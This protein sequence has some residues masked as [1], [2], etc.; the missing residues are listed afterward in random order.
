M[1]NINWTRL[2]DTW[3]PTQNRRALPLE[4]DDDWVHYIRNLDNFSASFYYMYF[5]NIVRD[6][7]TFIFNTKR[8]ISSFFFSWSVAKKV[9][10]KCDYLEALHIE[11]H[12]HTSNSTPPPPLHECGAGGLA[13]G[14]AGA[15]EKQKPVNLPRGKLT[16]TY[17]TGPQTMNKLGFRASIAVVGCYL[18]RFLMFSTF[19]PLDL[20]NKPYCWVRKSTMTHQRTLDRKS[21]IP[22]LIMVGKSACLLIL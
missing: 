21:T 22:N 16:C 5:F 18:A 2:F 8:P 9:W 17:G 4:L 15:S 11:M 20:H 13:F 1:E 14:G 10:V 7:I 3:K 19:Y 6:H 12:V